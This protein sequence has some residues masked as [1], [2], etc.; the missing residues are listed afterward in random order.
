MRALIWTWTCWSLKAVRDA[1]NLCSRRIPSIC[2][3]ASPPV[4]GGFRS[5]S[6][7]LSRSPAA[8]NC[9]YRFTR[10]DAVAREI[11]ISRAT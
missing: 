8:L 3:F 10:L 5:S 11:P 7:D 6:H 2:V 4:P 9:R 1:D